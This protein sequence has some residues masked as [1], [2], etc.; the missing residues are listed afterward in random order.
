M[1]ECW[2]YSK[3]ILCVLEETSHAEKID[4]YFPQDREV[5]KHYK[6]ETTSLYKEPV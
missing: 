5:G 4:L 1:A 6:E 2:N 3:P